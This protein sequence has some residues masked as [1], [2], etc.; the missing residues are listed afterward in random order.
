MQCRFDGPRHRHRHR[1]PSA[2]ARLRHVP[3]GRQLRDALVRRRRA[4]A[5][6]REDVSSRSSAATVQAESAVGQGSTSPSSLPLAQPSAEAAP[7]RRRH[8]GASEAHAAE[9]AAGARVE[10]PEADGSP[11]PQPTCAHA[12][13]RA[14]LFADDLPLNRLLVERFIARE[15]PASRSSRPAT[16]SR[17]STMF[18]RQQ[19]HLVVLD[20]HMPKLD[21]WQAARDHPP[22]AR[23]VARCRS[24]LSAST[25]AR[26]P[27][28]TP[29]APAS[30]SSSRSRSATTARSVH[31]W[32]TGSKPP[33]WPRPPDHTGREP[34]SA[35]ACRDGGEDHDGRRV[36]ACQRSLPSHS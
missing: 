26:S 13:R 10:D 3:A 21:G 25:P 6:H 4:R 14:L 36:A 20:L 5:L 34:E 12:T 11:E 28:P 16:A 23:A 15:F 7:R 27:K 32:S 1:R 8:D 33:R 9:R 2:A 24:W 29:S 19:P 22:T 17:P 31:A 30:R 35:S 18:E